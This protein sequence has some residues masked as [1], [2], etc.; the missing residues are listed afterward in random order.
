MVAMGGNVRYLTDFAGTVL[1]IVRETAQV[2]GQTLTLG[3]LSLALAVV[4]WFAVS[5][6]QNPP[7]TRFFSGMI[8]VQAVNVPQG[9]APTETAQVK[10]EVTADADI[11]DELSIDD[12]KATVD[13]SGM[14]Q[15]VANLP[16]LV[17]SS[18]SDVKIVRV[19][20]SSIDVTLEPVTTASRPV[21]I[22]T[23]AVAP[24]G[25]TVTDQKVSPETVEVSGP[26]SLVEQTDAVWVDLNLTG[27]KVS[28]ERDFVLTARDKDGRPVD[29]RI[30]PN[31]AKV[32]VTI[33]RTEW[34][35]TFPVNPSI[36]G[37]VAAGYR[38][39][40]VEADP[41]FVNVR[42]PVD[43][44]QSI[45]TLTTD[46]I[47]VDNAQS[48]VQ[49]NVKLR[50]PTGASVDG[51]DEVVVSVRIEPAPGQRNF[52]I[53]VQPTGLKQ[54][55]TASFSPSEVTVT[56]AGELPIL[57][58][59]AGDAIVAKVD[60]SGLAPGTYSLSPEIEVPT[61]TLLVGIAPPDVQVTISSQ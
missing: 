49:R 47:P 48:D 19:V 28:L 54:G 27:V 15:A 1:A 4:I 50:L 32:S 2:V 34:Q 14:T 53:A 5:D 7:E 22:N 46:T 33:T 59:L 43:V 11:W 52:Q 26:Q 9:K 57:D 55:L 12:F 20:P 3:L 21:Q 16:V 44:L 39:A 29:V 37:D 6:A 24:A 13:L 25:F 38:V 10:V 58:S 18:R 35:V 23:V 30:Q 40:A 17:A 51:S 8:P 60:L 61:D 42:G 45:S 56:L 41:P 31:T 36:S